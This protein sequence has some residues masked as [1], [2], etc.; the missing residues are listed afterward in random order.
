[1]EDFRLRSSL[2]FRNGFLRQPVIDLWAKEMSKIFLKK[3][4]NL[5]FRR[6]EYKALLTIDTDQPFAY[7]GKGLFRSIGG[8]FR[9]I[10]Q[11]PADMLLTDIRTVAKG[12]KDPYR[13]I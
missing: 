6:N 13:G 9:D 8:L 10:K 2:A 4:Q 3:F 11:L 1:M 12:E 5:V 7:L